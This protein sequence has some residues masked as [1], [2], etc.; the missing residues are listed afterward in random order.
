MARMIR[1]ISSGPSPAMAG[2]PGC[3]W[4]SP[5]YAERR[6]G[7]TP[8][9]EG[10]GGSAPVRRPAR[11][12]VRPV[13]RRLDLVEER[14]RVALGALELPAEPADGA[15]H[16]VCDDTQDDERGHEH[17]GEHEPEQHGPTLAGGPAAV[18][19]QRGP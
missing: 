19:G 10:M 18:A 17:A 8:K 11:H 16:P 13:Q 7:R 2:P 15:Q 5:S 12:L 1:P 9:K 6:P 3:G 4:H 14:A